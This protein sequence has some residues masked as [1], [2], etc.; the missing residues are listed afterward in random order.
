MSSEADLRN[1]FPT[2]L[3]QAKSWDAGVESLSVSKAPP[4]GVEV[5]VR[6]HQDQLFGPVL[7]F[8]YGK[9]AVEVWEDV[10]YR[11]VPLTGKDAKLDDSRAKRKQPFTG[12]RSPARAESH[13]SWK[14]C[15]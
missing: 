5:I 4:P 11:I 7:S 2:L 10:A 1:A 14:R 15:F 3:A 12:I 6:L 9:M 8:G 13:L